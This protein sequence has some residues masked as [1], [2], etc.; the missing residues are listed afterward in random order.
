[1]KHHSLQHH[2]TYI[3]NFFNTTSRAAPRRW[4]W[5]WKQ[6]SQCHAWGGSLIV[7]RRSDLLARSMGMKVVHPPGGSAEKASSMLHLHCHIVSRYTQACARECFA[8]FA[9]TAV[10]WGWLM[11]T[12]A[13]QALSVAIRTLFSAPTGPCKGMLRALCRPYL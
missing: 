5:K 8:L 1:M 7:P 13:C 2:N 10:V 4:S 9:D 12:E 6:L 11:C 3:H